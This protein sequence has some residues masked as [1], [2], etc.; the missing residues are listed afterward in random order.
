MPT[1]TSKATALSVLPFPKLRSFSP[2]CDPR[3]GS[4]L[5]ARS[6]EISD[7]EA[8]GQSGEDLESNQE[9][10]VTTTDLALDEAK[11]EEEDEDIAESDPM[12]LEAG[13]VLSEQIQL[14]TLANSRRLALVKKIEETNL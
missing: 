14:Q 3:P 8:S 12:L 2:T 5:G 6:G 4:S 11:D 10:G 1:I 7:S 13:K 9:T